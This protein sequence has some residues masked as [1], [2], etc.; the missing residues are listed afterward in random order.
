MSI[1]DD[2]N[3]AAQKLLEADMRLRTIKVQIDILE[4]EIRLLISLEAQLEENIRW[5][6][7]RKVITVAN[8]YRK[9]KE[10]LQ[11]TLARCSMLK[12]DKGNNMKSYDYAEKIYIQAKTEHDIALDRVHNPRYNVIEV[13]FRRRSGQK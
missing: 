8:E 11:K 9:A 13:D 5:L 2:L 3:Q 1:T 7:R 10:D 6:K 12:I 4:R